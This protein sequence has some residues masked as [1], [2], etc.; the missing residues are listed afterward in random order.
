MWLPCKRRLARKGE[1]DPLIDSALS[2]S[3]VSRIFFFFR[4]TS[5]HHFPH[6][7]TPYPPVIL[8][9]RECQPKGVFTILPSSPRATA[10]L[11]SKFG[12]RRG[13]QRRLCT[14]QHAPHTLS[15]SHFFFFFFLLFF[16]CLF[17]AK[18]RLRFVL[19]IFSLFFFFFFFLLFFLLLFYF[20][21]LCVC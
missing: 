13:G 16:F 15:T 12:A 4:C 11:S 9:S 18:Q 1:M 21:F 20:S 19:P 2:L 14:W 7:L 6:P 10:S 8:H 17:L 5:T 3:P